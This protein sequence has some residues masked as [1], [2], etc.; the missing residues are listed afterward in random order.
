MKE[1]KLGASEGLLVCD[2]YCFI[3][4]K[5]IGEEIMPLD[6]MWGKTQIQMPS[7]PACL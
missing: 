2:Y 5:I 7:F 6:S 3:A 1:A 4:E